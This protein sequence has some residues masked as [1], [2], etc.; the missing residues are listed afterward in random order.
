MAPLALVHGGERFDAG[1]YLASHPGGKAVLLALAGGSIDEAFED[2]GHS[3]EAREILECLKRRHAPPKA[4]RASRLFTSEDRFMLHKLLACANLAL[5]LR[6][7]TLIATSSRPLFEEAGALHAAHVFVPGALALTG[8]SFFHTPR[9]RPAGAFSMTREQ[10]LHTLV[11]SLRSCF[12]CAAGPALRLLPEP[13]SAALLALALFNAAADDVTEKHRL[14]RAG[15]AI[16][17]S[18]AYS[19]GAPQWLVRAYATLSSAMQLG[20]VSQMLDPRAPLYASRCYVVL[21][22]IQLAAFQSTLTKK[23]LISARASGSLYAAELLLVAWTV[24]WKHSALGLSA[25]ALRVLGVPKLAVWTGVALIH[26]L[27]TPR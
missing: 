5:L 26:V 27:S 7:V 14:V 8:A 17:D 20:A 3:H 12:F 25:L 23:A 15:D 16:R 11:F 24:E 18:L 6:A 2:V 19:D 21:L 4:S 1:E 10:Q 9:A 13:E 22:P